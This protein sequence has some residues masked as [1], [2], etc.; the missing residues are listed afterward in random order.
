VNMLLWAMQLPVK[1]DNVIQDVI[2]AIESGQFI[3]SIHAQ[4]RMVERDINFSDVEEAVYNSKREEGK[5]E[6][7]RDGKAWKYALRGLN[8]NQD[9]DI[10]LVVLYLEN[11]KML[12]VTV[13]NTNEKAG[14]S[15]VK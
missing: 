15:D 8:E 6:L 10:R 12:L 2:S 14:V 3:P 5:D 13:I 1:K 7:T 11:P 4:S 9:K